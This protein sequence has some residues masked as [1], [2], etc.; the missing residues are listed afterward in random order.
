MECAVV[1]R[2]VD[3]EE[4]WRHYLRLQRFGDYRT[5]AF[6]D[7]IDNCN[8]QETNLKMPIMISDYIYRPFTGNKG[9]KDLDTDTIS[10][11]EISSPATEPLLSPAISKLKY[12]RKLK[13]PIMIS[14]YI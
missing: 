3:I 10:N 14:D 2:R 12:P 13:M 4:R 11:Q 9:H 7:N 1:N 5:T 6:S 8:L